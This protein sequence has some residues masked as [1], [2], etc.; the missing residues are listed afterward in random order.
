MVESPSPDSIGDTSFILP[1]FKK[2]IGSAIINQGS[3]NTNIADSERRRSSYLHN[4]TLRSLALCKK[5]TTLLHWFIP[6]LLLLSHCEYVEGLPSFLNPVKG[7]TPAQEVQC[8]SIP[9]G[10]IGFASHILT[11]YTLVCLWYGRKPLWPMSPLNHV[12]LDFI[13]A[14]L[15][16][17]IAVGLAVFT[18]I[19]CRNRYEFMLIAIWKIFMTTV[20]VCTTITAPVI[21]RKEGDATTTV[22]WVILY[23]PGLITGFVG[24]C[25]LVKENW[26]NNVVRIV[27]YVFGGVVIGI[28]VIAG[29][30]FCCRRHDKGFVE[31]WLWGIAASIIG[32][33]CLGAIYSDW[34]LG[35]I[36]ENLVGMPSSDNMVLYWGY[37]IAK[38]LPLLSI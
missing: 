34:I 31:A 16:L 9:Y 7:N 14:V 4:M 30:I 1:R 17:F 38:R 21:I 26:D 13:W 33:T 37:F 29:V 11:Y 23:I 19:R 15:T 22:G 24:L 8:Y 25:P 6:I 20:L 5:I 18:I 3:R 35:A 10:G 27:T 28:G 32:W 2:V 12:W 36:A